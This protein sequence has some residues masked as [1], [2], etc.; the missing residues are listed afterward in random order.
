MLCEISQRKINTVWSL[1]YVESKKN[2]LT[3]AENR[4]VVDRGR[5]WW[6]GEL[7]E[8]GQMVKP[9]NEFGRHNV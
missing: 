9:P 5:A 7:G 6:I 2:E 1:L 3:G 8:G 4:M